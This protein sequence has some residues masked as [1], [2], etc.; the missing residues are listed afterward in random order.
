MSGMR[1]NPIG[2]NFTTVDSLKDL[3]D[4]DKCSLFRDLMFD[5]GITSRFLDST[6]TRVAINIINEQLQKCW[7]GK[8]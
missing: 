2:G 4:R 7:E 8:L 3:P 1:Y 5:L 6:D